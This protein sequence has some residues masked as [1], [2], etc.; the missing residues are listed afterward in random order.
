MAMRRLLALGLTAILTGCGEASGPALDGKAENLADLERRLEILRDRL[1]IPGLSAGIAEGNHIVWTKGFGQAD[2]DRGIAA[3]PTTGFHVASLTKGFAAVILVK[4]VSQGVISL[5]DPVTKFGVSIPGDAGIKVRHLVNMT[6]E[7][8]PGRSFNY[9]GDRYG[10]LDQVITSATGKTLGELVVQQVLQP[11]Q[12]TRTAPNDRSAAFNAAGIDRAVFTAN[13]ATGYE[14][15]RAVSYPT[16][17]GAAAGLI[18]TAEDMLKFSIAIDGGSLLTAAER[19]M[20]FEA[21]RSTSG[22]TLPY[23]IGWFSQTINGVAIQW[24]YGYW[25]GN[26][27]LI[28]RVPSRQRVFVALA[29][30]DGLSRRFSL[31]SGDL[32][33]S[34]VAKEFLEAFIFGNS[35]LS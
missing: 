23:A 9:N 20:M 24:A 12:M 5:D 21:A 19:T 28:I 34:S 6:S 15:N 8:T 2:I 13:L 4:L 32:L 30:S 10:L 25:I 14:S 11:V 27:A 3:T 22:E 26:S 16:Y 7:G 31:G 1:D 35:P 17:F 29:N 18:S 33:S